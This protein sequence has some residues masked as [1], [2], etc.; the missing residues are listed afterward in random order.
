MGRM[1]FGTKVDA[2]AACNNGF[3]EKSLTF[4]SLTELI[5]CSG[6]NRHSLSCATSIT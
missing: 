5:A 1:L 6:P 3:D 4:N 2:S